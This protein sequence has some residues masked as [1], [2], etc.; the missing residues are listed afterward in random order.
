LATLSATLRSLSSSSEVDNRS[1]IRLSKLVAQHGTNIT[2]SRREAERCIRSG[3][4]TV[5]GQ[6][7]TSPTF[8][9]TL[10]EA[11]SAIKVKGKLLLVNQKP[12]KIRVWLI[13]KLRGEVVSE[14]DPKERPSL[15]DRLKRGLGIHLMP[16]GRLDMNTE[17]LII[18]TTDGSYARQ[19]ELPRNQV[20]RTYRVRVH[21]L[22][23]PHKLKAM[24]SGITINNTRYRGMQVKLEDTRRKYT[25]IRITCTEGKNRQIR[26]VLSHLGCK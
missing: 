1:P 6:V 3:D 4:V 22:L 10:S 11:A 7:I 21:G 2:M 13:H 14:R 23:T 19:L 9:V 24:R 20:H 12:Q 17:G 25:W 26:N 5:A 18:L 8:S 15:V 16:V